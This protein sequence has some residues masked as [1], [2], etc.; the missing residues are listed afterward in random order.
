MKMPVFLLLLASL[1]SAFF[2][3]M[4]TQNNLV[5]G[6][7]QTTA[8]RTESGEPMRIQG[9]NIGNALDAPNPGGWGVNIKP[10]YFEKIR[11]AGF[12][13]VRLPVR[14][15]GHAQKTSPYKIDPKFLQQ[16][17]DTINVGLQQGLVIILDMHHYD[18]VMRNPDGE[19][20]R[21]LAIW[22]ELS[23]HY[24]NF[25]PNLYFEILNEP[26]QQMT[27]D[28]WNDL[29]KSTIELIREK[30]PDRW[31]L[32][33]A[34]EFSD[35]EMLPTLTLPDDKHLIATFHY[36]EPFP[37]THQGA[38]WVEGSAKWKGSKW[39]GNEEEKSAITVKLDRAALWSQ[40]KQIPLI[41]GEFGTIDQ[42]DRE[43]RLRWTTFLAREAEKRNIGW[44]HWQFCSD[45]PVY[46]CK[47]DQW[48]QDMLRALIPE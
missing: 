28:R 14:F 36:Y 45:F 12:N 3:Q 25:P 16:V 9:V 40:E 39:P 7:Q 29:L 26:S 38:S 19:E 22:R 24:E 6:K 23:T 30:N 10:E 17:D 34:G 4:Q 31:I 37:F 15:S 20:I 2:W 47:T 18:E 41:M 13:T 43:S 42:A 5:S 27:R 8:F 1:Y 48:D 46:S 44:I 33:D 21:F 35:I 32:I 11:T